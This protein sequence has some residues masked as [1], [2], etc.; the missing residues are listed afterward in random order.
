M[1]GEGENIPLYKKLLQEEKR[2]GKVGVG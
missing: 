1:V 2:R